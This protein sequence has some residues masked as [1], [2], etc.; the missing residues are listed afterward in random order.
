MP[1]Y[2][3][4][5]LIYLKVLIHICSNKFLQLTDLLKILE[6]CFTAKSPSISTSFYWCHNIK[7]LFLKHV[8]NK[9]A[10][11]YR[12]LPYRGSPWTKAPLD[13]PPTRT[14]TPPPRLPCGQTNASET[15]TLPQTL[16]TGGKNVITSLA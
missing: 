2:P 11:K 14:E 15:I 9:N 3:Q 13:R 5:K 1:K 4:T 8:V 12:S 16:F 6:L 7:K 10:F